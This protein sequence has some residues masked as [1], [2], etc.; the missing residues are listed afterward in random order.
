MTLSLPSKK[1]STAACARKVCAWTVAISRPSPA[2][3]DAASIRQ[4]SRKPASLLAATSTSSSSPICL[5]AELRS[6]LLASAPRLPHRR[7]PRH[8]AECTSLWTLLPGMFPRTAPNSVKRKSP[9]LVVNKSFA[10][11]TATAALARTSSPAK[12]NAILRPNCC[13]APSCAKASASCPHRTSFRFATA[14]VANFPACPSPAVAYK[15]PDRIPSASAASW[16]LCSKTSATVSPNSPGRRAHEGHVATIALG[17]RPSALWPGRISCNHR[18]K[19]SQFDFVH[20]AGKLYVPGAE[21]IISNLQRL[22]TFAAQHGIPIVASTGGRSRIQPIPTPLPRRH[23]W[24]E[25]GRGYALPVALHHSKPQD[26]FAREPRLLSGDH[27]RKADRR[28]V[29]ESQHRFSPETAGLP[30]DHS[31]RRGHRNLRRS[32][33]PRPDPARLPCSLGRGRHPSPRFA[34]SA[35]DVAGN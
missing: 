3:C 1:S 28:R 4:D 11:P 25:K 34:P 9:I 24:T 20:P 15:T 29:H 32:R 17:C 6:M 13:S 14:P 21:A 22:T 31:L 23:V 2:R 26:R 18:T 12:A 5:P 10:C 33:G 19:G 35:S 16:K 30:R 8:S 27:P 7:T